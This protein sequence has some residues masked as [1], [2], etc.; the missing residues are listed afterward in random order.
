VLHTINNSSNLLLGT[1][2]GYVVIVAS[3]FAKVQDRERN[4]VAAPSNMPLGK[5]RVIRLCGIEDMPS[6]K[7]GCG[8]FN[9]PESYS[10]S[11]ITL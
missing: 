10:G 2:C 6:S 7:L 1:Q 4:P 11:T 3:N 8:F 9:L 5:A